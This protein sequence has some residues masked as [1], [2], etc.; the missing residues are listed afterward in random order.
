[1]GASGL[2]TGHT[3]HPD[4]IRKMYVTVCFAMLTVYVAVQYVVFSQLCI[5]FLIV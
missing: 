1:M 3:R 4:L 2:D 5:L